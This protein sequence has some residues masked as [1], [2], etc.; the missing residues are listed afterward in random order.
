MRY[1]A[2][3]VGVVAIGAVAV[4][5][6][7]GAA[8]KA[9]KALPPTPASVTISGMP[10]NGLVTFPSLTLTMAQLAALP[11]STITVPVGGVTKT[12]T[13]PLVSSLLTQAG[14]APIAACTNDVLRYWTEVSSLDGGAVEIANGEL[15]TGFGNRPAILS[16]QEN[17]AAADRSPARGSERPDRRAQHR[18]RLQHHGRSRCSAAGRGQRELQS[19]PGSR[20]R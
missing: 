12:E 18:Q 14:F 13:G 20:H 19:R 5:Q 4:V 6:G 10:G 16:I 17:G 15:N 3:I 1:F 11:Q 9:T 8:S 7:S 2:A